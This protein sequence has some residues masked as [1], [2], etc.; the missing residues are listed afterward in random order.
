MAPGFQYSQTGSGLGVGRLR[1]VDPAYLSASYFRE[2]AFGHSN[3]ELAEVW[4]REF[5]CSI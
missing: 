5:D 4:V 2:D 3:T 1:H